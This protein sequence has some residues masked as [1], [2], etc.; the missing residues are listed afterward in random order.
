MSDQIKVDF[1][2]IGEAAGNISSAAQK[3]QQQLDDLKSR[4]QP[5]LAQWE[6]S[7]SGAYQ[8]AQQKWDTS[9]ADIQQVL[10]SIGTA[11]QQANEAYEQ[12]ERANQGR[13]S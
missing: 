3:V 11:V 10:A 8:E 12:A 13:W 4:L 5:V 2:V 6:G 1:A 7:A 9:A